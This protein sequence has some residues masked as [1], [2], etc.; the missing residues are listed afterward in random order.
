MEYSKSYSL[1][2]HMWFDLF[3]K[4]NNYENL[5]S[6]HAKSTENFTALS[7]TSRTIQIDQL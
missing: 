2:P 1:S 7:N 6:V 3:L 5:I 4:N